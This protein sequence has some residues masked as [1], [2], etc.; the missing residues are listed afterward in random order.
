MAWE[1]LR[2][3]Y[4]LKAQVSLISVDYRKIRPLRKFMR[5]IIHK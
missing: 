1:C 5:K 4:I 2:S 3:D